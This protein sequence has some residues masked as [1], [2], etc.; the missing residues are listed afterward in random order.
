ML[1]FD[2]HAFYKLKKDAIG[3]DE[4]KGEKR[5]RGPRKKLSKHKAVLYIIKQKLK[6][7]F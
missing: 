2:N 5:K 3:K 4:R 6:R 1:D 7:I